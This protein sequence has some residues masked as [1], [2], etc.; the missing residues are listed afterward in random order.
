MTWM[1]YYKIAKV[2]LKG[3]WRSKPS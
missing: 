3:P 1:K 2:V